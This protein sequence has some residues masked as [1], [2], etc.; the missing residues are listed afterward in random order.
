MQITREGDFIT[1][2]DFLPGKASLKVN[3]ELLERA[4]NQI[5]Q[6]IEAPAK[7]FDLPL[8]PE[9]TE[10]QR[11]VWQALQQI[12]A[13][14][15]RTYGELARQLGSSPRAV[16]NACRKNPIPLVIPCHRVVSA[17]GPG[18]FSGETEGEKVNLK[19][20]LL[21]HEGVEI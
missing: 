12:P 11:R 17:S 19:R 21:L 5:H 6:Y 20:R 14:E 3:D 9:G 1:E 7:P 10:F 13:G 18:G 16:G 2:I 15:V 4:V 8:R